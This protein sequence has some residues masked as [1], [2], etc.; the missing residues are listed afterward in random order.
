MKQK[1]ISILNFVYTNELYPEE[2]DDI[3]LHEMAFDEKNIKKLVESPA[4]KSV[5]YY[6]ALQYK[7]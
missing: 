6:N 5:S 3:V 4:Y 7:H 1:N 2:H